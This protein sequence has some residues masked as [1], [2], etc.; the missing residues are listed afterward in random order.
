MNVP[1]SLQTACGLQKP[2]FT[3]AGAS[4]WVL[5]QGFAEAVTP[6]HHARSL[7]QRPLAGGAPKRDCLWTAPRGQVFVFGV[8]VLP[9]LWNR[10]RYT[11]CLDNLSKI[12]E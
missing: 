7:Q 3:S 9:L 4:R 12:E 5:P 10:D 1:G 6:R 11:L 8:C 2:G